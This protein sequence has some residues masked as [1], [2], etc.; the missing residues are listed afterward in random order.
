M[1]ELVYSSCNLHVCKSSAQVHTFLLIGLLTIAY[2]VGTSREK[3]IIKVIPLCRLLVARLV[4]WVHSS[5]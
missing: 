1:G 2:M 5:K 3:K 4:A